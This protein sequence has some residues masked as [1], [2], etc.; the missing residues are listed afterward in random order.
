[1]RFLPLAFSIATLTL[2]QTPRVQAGTIVGSVGS[3]SAKVSLTSSEADFIAAGAT[4]FSF[5]NT[6]LYVGTYQRDE[7]NQESVVASF[8]NGNL[9]WRQS[10]IYEF[11]PPD[12]KGY[13][14]VWDGADDLYAV[15]TVDGG[16]ASGGFEQHTGQGWLSS[17]GPS[18]GAKAGSVLL[19]LNPSDG[20]PITGTFITA[21]LGSEPNALANSVI[22]TGLSLVDGWVVYEGNSFYSPLRADGKTIMD[23]S[24]SSPFDYR[25]IFTGNLD[26]VL[27]AEALRC[28]GL[29]QEQG[30]TAI[31]S[32]NLGE[33]NPTD[34]DTTNPDTTNPD[35]TNPDTTNPDTTN[36]D[37]TN[38]D[39]TN[40][41]TTN[42]DTTNPDTT[43]PD[44]TNPDTDPDGENPDGEDLTPDT[45][46]EPLPDASS[47]PEP[48]HA[49]GVALFAGV[50]WMRQTRDRHRSHRKT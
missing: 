35:T 19:K 37:T 11:S 50:M 43:N 17:F 44:T 48:S 47:V 34:P 39:T 32:L 1:M 12:S 46:Q 23:C 29:T 24:G 8:T 26:R 30:F 38:P 16:A 9:D 33:S 40:P 42:P 5:G 2:M 41:D 22:P 15:F 14:L 21:R 6:T 25:L 31:G 27:N 36:P 13:G 18:S 49:I 20:T 4:S 28:D 10:S 45:P 3:S 7:I